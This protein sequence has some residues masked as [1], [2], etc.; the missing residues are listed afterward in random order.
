MALFRC[1]LDETGRIQRGWDAS[2]EAGTHPKRLGRIQRGWLALDSRE[3]PYP[4]LFGYV[5]FSFDASCLG[6]R[7]QRGWDASKEAGAPPPPFFGQTLSPS[8]RSG[9]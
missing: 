6:G 7:I 4:T 3:N 5:L 9:V 8:I 1:D 2:K